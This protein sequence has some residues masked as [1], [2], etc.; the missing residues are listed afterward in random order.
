VLKTTAAQGK[1]INLAPIVIDEI[2]VIGSRCGPFAPALR[3]LS[4]KALDVKPLISSIYKPEQAKSA[5][6]KAA[7]K[8]SLKVIFHFG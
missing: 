4:K 2:Q 5:F 1:E 6:K 8:D 3:A 7:S